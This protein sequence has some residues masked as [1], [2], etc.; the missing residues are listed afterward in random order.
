VGAEGARRG[1]LEG[2]RGPE[3]RGLAMTRRAVV[4][5]AL[6]LAMLIAPRAE[7]GEKADELMGRVAAYVSQFVTQFSNV[8]A[9]EDYV[10]EQSV[11]RR[12]RELKSD[13]MLVKYPGSTGWLMF[14]D[15]ATVDGKPVRE[16]QE[17]LTDLFLQPFDDAVARAREISRAAD[18]YNLV[19]IGNIN[20]PL[21][22][23]AL[24][25]QDYQSHFHYTLSGIDRKVGEHVRVVHFEERLRPT[26]LRGNANADLQARG[27]AWVE[28]P[29]GRVV[30]TELQVG[31][32][33]FPIRITTTYT[34]DDTL[35]IT[36]PSEMREWYPDGAGEL[37][38]L[39]TYSH[40]RRF[41]VKTEEK[42]AD[43]AGGTT[44]R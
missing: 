6:A 11:P 1:R 36:V 21:L 7:A 13:Y 22:A 19:Y 15:V 12:K 18:Q 14:R 42:V 30:K 32:F 38:G 8:V 17:R 34:F 23:L 10:Q 35:Q 20:N 37:T 4:A 27:L 40:F 28:E 41:Q 39:A 25:Q 3:R 31:G 29:T 2:Q 26:I 43:P 24:L 9:E 5:C 33:Q 44:S 16:Q